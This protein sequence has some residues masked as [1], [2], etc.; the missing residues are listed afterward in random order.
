VEALEGFAIG[1]ADG[2]IGRVT[3]FHFD[4]AAWVIRYLIVNTSNWWR[5]HQMLVSPEW[6][7]GIDWGKSVA[8]VDGGTRA[9]TSV[10]YRTDGRRPGAYRDRAIRPSSSATL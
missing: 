1:G 4:D 7:K 5:G 2:V 6:I 9:M 8:T 3:D 10:R